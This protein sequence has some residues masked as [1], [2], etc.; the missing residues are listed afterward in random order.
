MWAF[1]VTFL[2][3]VMALAVANHQPAFFQFLCID[4]RF[5]GTFDVDPDYAK[6]LYYNLCYQMDERAVHKS[7]EDLKLTRIS[8]RIHPFAGV[9]VYRCVFSHMEYDDVGVSLVSTPQ[10]RR[11]YEIYRRAQMPFD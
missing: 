1:L 2:S 8:R 11:H 6:W 10:T 5:L 9:T 7:P 4:T 3:G